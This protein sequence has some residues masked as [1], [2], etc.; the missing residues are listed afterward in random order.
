MRTSVSNENRCHSRFLL[1]KMQMSYASTQY[2]HIS[3]IRTYDAI[4]R[5][6]EFCHRSDSPASAKASIQI[7]IVETIHTPFPLF[8]T[9]LERVLESGV[10]KYKYSEYYST[11]VQHSAQYSSTRSEEKSLTVCAPVL[12]LVPRACR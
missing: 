5:Q 2:V 3:H 7:W 1:Y 6:T 11:P 8:T 12:S 9:L 4:T 10:L